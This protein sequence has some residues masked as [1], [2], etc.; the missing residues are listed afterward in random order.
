MRP[1]ALPT[2]PVRNLAPIIAAAK[3]HNNVVE[4]SFTGAD[5]GFDM[6]EGH[7]F[8]RSL[9][10]QQLDELDV[11][12]VYEMNGEPLLPQHGAPLRI[13]VPGWYGMASVKVADDH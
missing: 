8:G 10:L 1:S 11:M 6:G 12:L 4:I 7:Y 2:G 5:Y 3:P 13:I 9:T